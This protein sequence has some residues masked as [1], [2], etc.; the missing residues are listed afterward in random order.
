MIAEASQQKV[1]SKEMTRPLL[2]DTGRFWLTSSQERGG[3][4]APNHLT[5][6]AA[7]VQGQGHRERSDGGPISNGYRRVIS[8][9]VP[10]PSTSRS[11]S[12]ARPFGCCGA[13]GELNAHA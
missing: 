9:P 7:D 10:Q 4:A 13:A 1:Q 5:F 11:P 8:T 2:I 3:S 6:I 12:C